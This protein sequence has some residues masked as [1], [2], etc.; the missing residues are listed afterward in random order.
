MLIMEAINPALDPKSIVAR[1]QKLYRD[2][3]PKAI[4]PQEVSP[5][6]PRMKGS[7]IMADALK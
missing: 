6:T 2:T 7:M 4:N 3:N 5:A 1:M